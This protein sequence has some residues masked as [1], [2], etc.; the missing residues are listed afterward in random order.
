MITK[1]SI[2]I[3][4]RYT[5]TGGESVKPAKVMYWLQMKT[6]TSW[7]LFPR[8]EDGVVCVICRYKSC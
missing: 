7:L 6:D 8:E 1:S 5:Q 4:K 2:L 3:S